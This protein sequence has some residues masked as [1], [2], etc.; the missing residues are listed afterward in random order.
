MICT[1]TTCRLP[2]YPTLP[3]SGSGGFDGV[4]STFEAVLPTLLNHFYL[5]T[6][7][8]VIN[9]S[10]G[11][12][13]LHCHNQGAELVVGQVGVALGSLDYGPRRSP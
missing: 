1:R 13:E 3:K 9:P 5:P 12:P 8:I 6:G 10:S 11:V 7:R 2:W 4:V